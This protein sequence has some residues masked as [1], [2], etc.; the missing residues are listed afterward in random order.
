MRITLSGNQFV[1]SKAH[2]TPH[3]HRPQYADRC[4]RTSCIHTYIHT[5]SWHWFHACKCQPSLQIIWCMHACLH[6]ACMCPHS[7]QLAMRSI[8]ATHA[9]SGSLKDNWTDRFSVCLA[10]SEWTSVSGNSPFTEQFTQAM[11]PEPVLDTKQAAYTHT[12]GLFFIRRVARMQAFIN[13][14]IT[15][16]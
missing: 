8:N 16:N 4:R 6:H 13:D 7:S 14:Q 10:S 9:V 5:H 12:V 3:I 15:T 1:T 11:Q 2:P